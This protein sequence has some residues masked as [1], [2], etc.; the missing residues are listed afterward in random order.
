VAKVGTSN[1]DR[2]ISLRLQCLVRKH[3]HHHSQAG[4]LPDRKPA[5]A[6]NFRGNRDAQGNDIKYGSQF[7]F[8]ITLRKVAVAAGFLY[9]KAVMS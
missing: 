9:D 4:N 7:S 2:T 6:R 1:S 5:T 8:I 3:K